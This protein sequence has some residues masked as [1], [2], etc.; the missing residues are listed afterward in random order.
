MIT[1]HWVWIPTLIGL[2][3][4]IYAYKR[5]KKSDPLNFIFTLPMYLIGLFIIIIAWLIRY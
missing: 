4:M 1:F 5:D 2:A 3:I